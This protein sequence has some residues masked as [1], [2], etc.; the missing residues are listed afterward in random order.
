MVVFNQP[1]LV[2]FEL[3]NIEKAVSSKHLRGDGP[4]TH[5]CQALI[6][7]AVAPGAKVLLT[8]SCT[9]ALEMSALLA[10]IA[11]GDEVIM[12]SY[13]FVST[14][15][16]VVLRGG[17]PVFV[18]VAP[19]TM[20]ISAETIEPGLS[21]RTKAVCV[22]H[23]AGVSVDMDPILELGRHHRLMII[24]DAAQAYQAAYKGRPCGG[25]ADL[26]AFSFHETKNIISGEGGALIVN[27]PELA[28]RSE[29]LW[30]KGTNRRQF[31]HGAVDKYTWVDVG[32]SFLPSELVAA[33]LKPQL[34]ASVEI[35]KRRLHIW[36]R[37]HAGLEDL[38]RRELLRRPIIPDYATHNAHMYYVL[39][40]TADTRRQILA[41]F[42]ARG[43]GAAFHYV[44][45]HSAPAG[46]RFARAVGALDVTD[47]QSARLLR[48]PMHAALAD[49][50]VDRVIA[51][52]TAVLTRLAIAGRAP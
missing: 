30:E 32:S 49:A 31:L 25:L 41:E 33:F 14:A 39:V 7:N 38:E 28:E 17:V 46:Q 22:V 24:E 50:D 6:A 4:M 18:D 51:D 11:P 48:L 52:L 27:A 10:Q 21:P 26:A 29:I 19:D 3:A 44:P 12:P 45:L 37:Y 9:A 23:Y 34:E 1:S 20:N 13:T 15:N 36:D 5:D 16:A 35:T 8:H 2:G 47:D 43:I 40:P 42:R